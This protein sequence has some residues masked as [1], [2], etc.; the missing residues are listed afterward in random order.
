MGTLRLTYGETDNFFVTSDEQNFIINK[1]TGN[2]SKQKQNTLEN[3][4][5]VWILADSLPGRQRKKFLE[6]EVQQMLLLL[7][8]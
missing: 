3:A 6:I 4:A 1:T 5:C 8:D 7:E 2:Y